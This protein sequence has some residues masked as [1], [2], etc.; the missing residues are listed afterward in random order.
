MNNNLYRGS[1]ETVIISLLN[2]HGEMYG[3]E[4][5]KLVKQNSDEK[6]VISEGA[7]Y[8]ILHKLEAN[9]IVESYTRVEDNRARKYY[10]LTEK[11][12]KEVNDYLYEMKEYLSVLQNLIFKPQFKTL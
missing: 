2:V 8:P 6:L 4:I 11:G 9:S 10:K 1:L 5:S 12:T 7:L 3:Y